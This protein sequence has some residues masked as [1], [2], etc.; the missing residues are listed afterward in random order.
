[1]QENITIY[2]LQII[3]S[4]VWRL[5]YLETTVTNRNCIHEEIKSMLNS[6]ATI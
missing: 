5:K 4:Q 1:M 2:W 3:P 6:E